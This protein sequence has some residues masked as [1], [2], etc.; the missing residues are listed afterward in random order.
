MPLLTMSNFS[1]HKNDSTEHPKLVQIIFNDLVHT[2]KRIPYFTIT[3]NDL[4]M[5][6]KE[7]ITVYIETHNKPISTECTIT[8][9]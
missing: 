8:D 2:P 1:T 4:L 7:I 3:K 6:Y 5:L 9:W